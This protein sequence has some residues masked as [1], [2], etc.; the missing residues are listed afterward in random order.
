MI[1]V[2]ITFNE[3]L[4]DYP[5]SLIWYQSILLRRS[6]SDH[7][8]FDRSS[9]FRVSSSSS[10]LAMVSVRRLRHRVGKSVAS[11]E[12]TPRREDS[13]SGS[14]PIGSN[15]PIQQ[16]PV[17]PSV[18]PAFPSAPKPS[19]FPP[20]DFSDINYSPYTLTNGDSPGHVIV[21]EVLDGTNFN[22][23]KIAMSVA[24]DAKNKLAFIDGSLPRP[25][26]SHP[27]F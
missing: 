1:N 7:P 14:S 24:L 12:K 8:P 27:S 11:A 3:K 23:W 26:E 10:T 16:P 21:S 25:S 4:R 15:V 22:S 5:L 20:I 9:S 17:F 2:I 18:P 6:H 19:M 13:A